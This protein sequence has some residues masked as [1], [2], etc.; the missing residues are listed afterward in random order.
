MPSLQH[1][2]QELTQFWQGKILWDFPMARF[3]TFKVGGPA[4]AVLVAESQDEL[5][6]L[7]QWLHKNKIHSYVIGKGSNILV[8]DTGLKGAV[9]V[10]GNKF[11]S[12]EIEPND[13]QE[14]KKSTTLVNAGAACL[15][16]KLVKYSTENNLS[17][18]EF[19]AGIPGSVGGA[20]VMNAGAWGGEMSDAIHSVTFMDP[21]GII[22][23]PG[24]EQLQFAYRKW[25][26][27]K[28]SIVLSG[29]FSLTKGEKNKIS[30]TCKKY[31]KARKIKQPL[32][33]PSAGS[34][35]KNPQSLP[36]G[37]LI[38]DAGLKGFSIGGAMVSPVH[39]N[40]IVNTG[41]A[42]ADDVFAVM[43]EVQDKVLHSSGIMLEPEVH[44]L[45][46]EGCQA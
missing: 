10:L 19:A 21:E 14:T 15:L 29:V 3:S 46:E 27:S 31:Q 22:M 40:F 43:Q 8:P 32:G 17:G 36:A 45:G 41:K 38:E 18:L 39:A 11:A 30:A 9:I 34:F 26:G 42:T 1:L 35:F 44:I 23:S 16:N 20:I 24:K 25:G 13:D 33:I 28:K 12:L 4:E 7:V 37:K 5:V 2:S 6:M